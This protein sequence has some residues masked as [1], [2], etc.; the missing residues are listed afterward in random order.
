MSLFK[1]M[2]S[3][4]IQKKANNFIRSL[5]NKSEKEIEQMYLDRKEFE[6]NEIVLSYLFFKHPSLIRILPLEFQ[7]ERIN[8]NLSNFNYGSSEAKKKLVSSWLKDNK[9]FMNANVVQMSDEEYETYLK[10]YFQ[11]PEDVAKL[12]MEDMMKVIETLSKIDLKSTEEIVKKIKDDLTDRQW[13]AIIKGCPS[14]IKFAS[15]N[16]QNQFLSD[17]RYNLYINGT[18]KQKYIETKLEKLK[19]DKSLFSTM[20]IDVQREYINNNPY[21]INYID[22]KSLIELLKYDIDLLRFLSIPA[23]ENN[24]EIIFDL[25]D[26]VENKS[27]KE[28][29]NIFINKGLVNAKGK[30]YRYDVKSEDISYQYTSKLL[31]IIQRLDINQIIS[32]IMTDVNYALAY[33]V[34]IY[35][36]IDTIEE[37]EK[38]IIDSNSR[39]LYLFKTYYGEEIYDKYYKVI[40]KIFNEYLSNIEK[41]NYTKDYDSLFDLFKVL[42]NKK[43]ITK[44]N[45]EKITVF[46]GLSLLYKNSSKTTNNKPTIKLLNEI[47]NTAYEINVNIDKEIYDFMSL[48][49]F[50]DRLNFINS[51]TLEEYF[52]FNFVH[53]SSLLFIAKTKK[54]SELFKNYYEI[55]KSIFDDNKE[56]LFKAVENFHYYIDILK[57][58]D[59]QKLTDKEEK[60]LII[61]IASLNNNYAITKKS[62]L[63]N[64]DIY[65]LKK[66]VSELSS[67]TD[68][69][70]INNL[71]CKYLFNK[72][73]NQKG[74]PGLLET[75]TIKEIIGLF[76]TNS[77]INFR[78]NNENI[79]TKEEANLITMLDLLFTPK[80]VDL[81]LSYME[82]ILENKESI[83]IVSVIN[84]FNKIK[85]YK[86]DI[87]NENIIT[88]DY[89]E[90]LYKQNSNGITKK[91]VN[92]VE[93]YTIIN[94]DFKLLCSPNNDGVYYLYTNASELD[95]NYYGYNKLE[96][97]GSVRLT[98]KDSKIYIKVNKDKKDKNIIKPEFIIVTKDVPDFIINSAKLLNIK[99]LLLKEEENLW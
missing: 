40:N 39:C 3:R 94:Q 90:N 88:L 5:N 53:I 71:I 70:I 63:E 42:F 41:Y 43:I 76:D 37:K 89:I 50:D 47:I 86:V 35:N 54:V 52:K 83:N 74:N 48:E 21:M 31:K 8:S 11:Q 13:E 95:K 61:L 72:G 79:F 91:V 6:D 15:Q 97:N 57:D 82:S 26:N 34:P 92:G 18:A 58:I 59:N 77:L 10:L 7:I 1:K 49:I 24:H 75:D 29:I 56:T 87:I 33:I 66:L 69:E 20:T 98:E 65:S 22:R 78:Y 28:I 62:E 44:N 17:E 14:M 85:K 23:L 12:Y 81:T 67:L 96:K 93:I 84:L 38:V 55:M 73:Y 64:Y 30:L 27:I 60:N 16:V 45:V 19:E 68:A 4:Q 36:E 80:D 99:V 25:L 46:I 32:L 2:Q 9:F 51:K